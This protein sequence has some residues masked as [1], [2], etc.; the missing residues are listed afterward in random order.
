MLII[1]IIYT[2]SSKNSGLSNGLSKIAAVAPAPLKKKFQFLGWI[3]LS[4]NA[5]FVAIKK[6][7]NYLSFSNNPRQILVYIDIVISSINIWSLLSNS[8][9][10]SDNSNLLLNSLVKNSREY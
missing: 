6:L 3:F 1:I 7:Y 8:E 2:P 10:C 9:L 5:I 4:V